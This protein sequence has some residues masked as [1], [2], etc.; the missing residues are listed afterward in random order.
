M[1]DDDVEDKSGFMSQFHSSASVTIQCRS[2]QYT[3]NLANEAKIKAVTQLNRTADISLRRQK[4]SVVKLSVLGNR[5][6]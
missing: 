1:N 4:L 5:R 6:K 3:N 2:L